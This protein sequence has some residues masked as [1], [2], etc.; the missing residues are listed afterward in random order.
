MEDLNMTKNSLAS[1]TKSNRLIVTIT[2]VIS[3]LLI[4]YLV[5]SLTHHSIDLYTIPKPSQSTNQPQTI[6]S[7]PKPIN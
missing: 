6:T 3:L 1:F 7:T 2:A 4:G 5:Y